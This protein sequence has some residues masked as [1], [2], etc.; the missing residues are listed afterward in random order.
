MAAARGN[1]RFT[2]APGV[3]PA[4]ARLDV[5]PPSGALAIELKD[6]FAAAGVDMR[7]R[8]FFLCISARPAASSTPAPRPAS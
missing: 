7:R 1:D 6:V 3:A 5:E 4:V 2:E 8:E